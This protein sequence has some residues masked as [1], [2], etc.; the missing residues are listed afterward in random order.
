MRRAVIPGYQFAP[1]QARVSVFD[2]L[3]SDDDAGQAADS[4]DMVRNAVHRDLEALLNAHRPWR[5]VAAHFPHLRLSSFCYGLPDFTSGAL[6]QPEP[7]EL[8][9]RDVET[10]IRRMEPRLTQVQVHLADEA[11]RLRAFLRLRIE[12]LLKVEPI[13]AQ[14]SFDTMVDV[15]TAEMT[16]QLRPGG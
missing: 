11:D 4:L 6:N 15:S 2:R 3:L 1:R 13:I 16:L 7:R 5:N 12:A 10:T 8:L 14:V 9:R